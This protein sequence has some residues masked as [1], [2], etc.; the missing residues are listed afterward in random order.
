M[1]WFTRKSIFAYRTTTRSYWTLNDFVTRPENE[2]ASLSFAQTSNFAGEPP[3]AGKY[4]VTLEIVFFP[5]A[6]CVTPGQSNWIREPY[7]RR[8]SCILSRYPFQ[9]FWKKQKKKKTAH[10]KLWKQTW[11]YRTISLRTRRNHL[12]PPL[13]PNE[14]LERL[15]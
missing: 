6:V 8:I 9:S 13:P 11:I 14:H 10:F 12:F 3:R 15:F 1:R 5:N 7:V 2:N 4:N